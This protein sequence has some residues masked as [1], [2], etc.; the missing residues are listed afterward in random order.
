M[1]HTME[2]YLK[3]D[4]KQDWRACFTWWTTGS[5]I[6]QKQRRHKPCII[7]KNKKNVEGG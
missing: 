3:Q 5:T 4:W 6:V 1:A 2:S 7:Y